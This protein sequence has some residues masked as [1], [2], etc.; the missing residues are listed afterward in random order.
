[1]EK[2]NL[3]SDCSSSLSETDSFDQENSF[4]FNFIFEKRFQGKNPTKEPSN[5]ITL[6][7]QKDESKLNGKESSKIGRPNGGRA[8]K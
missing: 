1:M 6:N 8:K 5:M 4:L 3:E 2:F 7:V